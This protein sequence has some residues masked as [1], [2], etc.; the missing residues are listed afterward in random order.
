MRKACLE[1]VI[2]SIRVL[3]QRLVDVEIKKLPPAKFVSKES[4]SNSIC[5][6][7]TSVD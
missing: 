3:F 2:E 5:I 4:K 1:K 6:A 7:R